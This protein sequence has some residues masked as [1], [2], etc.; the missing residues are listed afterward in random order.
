MRFARLAALVIFALALLATPL[1]AEAQAVRKVARI[2]ILSPSPA[3]AGRVDAVRQ[4]RRNLAPSKGKPSSSSSE[5]TREADRPALAAELVRLGVEVII[6][7]GVRIDSPRDAGDRLPFARPCGCS[8]RA[9]AGPRPVGLTGA[10][11]YFRTK[12]R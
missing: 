7:R 4:G 5:V 2:G 9:H 11:V 1:A 3:N 10:A 6:T 12:A 8:A